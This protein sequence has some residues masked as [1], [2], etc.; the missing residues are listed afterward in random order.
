[1]PPKRSA[2]GRSTKQ[3]KRRREERASET[4]VSREKLG[5]KDRVHTALARSLET[6]EQRQ[7]RQ[8]RERDKTPIGQHRRQFNAPT[9]DEV[10]IVRVGEEF[11]SRDII[12]H[13][14]NG[15][16]Q[17]VSETHRSYDALQYPILFC[18]GEY[19][20]HFNINMKNP[21]TNVDINKKVSAMNYYV[22]RMMIR[23]NAD[24]H[25]LKCR[26]LFHQYIVDMYA[27]LESERLLYIRLNQVK[28]CSGEYIYLR[29]AVVND[30]N[31]SELEK[32]VILPSTFTG[33]PRHKHEY[34]QDA[35]TYVRAY[36]RPDFFIT[37]TCNPAW[38]EVK[39]L[40]LTI[41]SS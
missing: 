25:I 14:R 28:L 39:E 6:N 23:E 13:R 4:S 20:Y 33:S 37:F 3:A 35:M 12:L 10:A 11:N 32:M 27:K 26:Q 29:D 8:Q 19:G 38:D 31:L 24:N 30:G 41:R 16:V 15:D 5:K 40:L 36:D 17:R 7:A 9:I 1:M 18:Q 22:Y 2:I 34:A 21:T